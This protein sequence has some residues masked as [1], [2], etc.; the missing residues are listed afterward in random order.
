MS[1]WINPKQA[2]EILGVKP[3]CFYEKVVPW[4]KAFCEKPIYKD[5]K[6]LVRYQKSAIEQYI[7]AHLVEC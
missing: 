3:T 4:I 7:K 5:G 2:M 6:R 1:D